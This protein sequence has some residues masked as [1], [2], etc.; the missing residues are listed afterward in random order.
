MLQQSFRLPEFRVT[1]A[2]GG[3]TAFGGLLADFNIAL[4]RR[5][6]V[7]SHGPATRFLRRLLK[8]YDRSNAGTVRGF[9]IRSSDEPCGTCTGPVVVWDEE[10][11]VTICDGDRSVYRQFDVAQDDRYFI[12]GSDRRVQDIGSLHELR[13]FSDPRPGADHQPRR[14]TREALAGQNDAGRQPRV[15]ES[16]PLRHVTNY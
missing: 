5:V 14:A 8:E 4:I 11:L 9:D 15:D 13:R 16:L 3:T 12:I 7:T 6:P 2:V 10:D 1:N